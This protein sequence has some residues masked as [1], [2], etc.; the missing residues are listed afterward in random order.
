VKCSV[1][2]QAGNT[3]SGGNSVT[4]TL[5][6]VYT[7]TYNL[8][9]PLK[10]NPA[11][12]SLVKLGAT[13]PVKFTAPNYLSGSPATDLA[14]GLTMSVS[15][16]NNPSADTTFEVTDLNSAGSTVWRYDPTTNQYV[17]NLSTKTGFQ[18]GEYDLTISYKGAGSIVV[19]KGAFNVKK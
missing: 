14:S 12:L 11:D 17:F 3:G 18:V 6:G 16:R 1:K 7:N 2:D 9:A 13:V 19:A 15:F 8:L 5:G 4:V 10:N